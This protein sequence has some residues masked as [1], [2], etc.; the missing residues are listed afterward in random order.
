[1]G[2]AI[3]PNPCNRDGRTIYDYNETQ[4]L[5][6][7]VAHLS[8]F[9]Q[10]N[11]AGGLQWMTFDAEPYTT[12]PNESFEQYF[13]LWYYGY[14]LK[15]AGAYYRDNYPVALFPKVA[16]PTG[17]ITGFKAAVSGLD[18]LLTWTNPGLHLQRHHDPLQHSRLPHQSH[19]RHAAGHSGRC[20]G[21]S[22]YIIQTRPPVGVR[23]YYAAF[24]FNISNPSL[25]GPQPTRRFSSERTTTVTEMWTSPTLPTCRRA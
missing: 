13:G 18:V 7:Y 12:N 16:L 3:Q 21:A 10:H 19:R 9:Q 17:P 25:P 1:M 14:G 11:I 22:D 2:L 6:V 15:P 24:P 20:P 23:H 5:S 4:Q 8:A